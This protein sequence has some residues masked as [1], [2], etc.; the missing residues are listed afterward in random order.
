MTRHWSGAPPAKMC[1]HPNGICFR[2]TSPRRRRPDG[3]PSGRSLFKS[4]IRAPRSEFLREPQ[5]E[6]PPLAELGRTHAD[7]RAVANLVAVVE[8]VDRVEA[9]LRALA[10][11]DRNLLH[12]RGVDDGVAG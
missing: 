2:P 9:D 7:P 5:Q 12:Q 4:L 1:V 11:A 6:R 3:P 8:Q 10:E